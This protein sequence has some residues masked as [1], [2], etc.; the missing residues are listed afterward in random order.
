MINKMHMYCAKSSIKMRLTL[1]ITNYQN[2]SDRNR[3]YYRIYLTY[4]YEHQYTS[5]STLMIPSFIFL[6]IWPW[7]AVLIFI[8]MYTKFKKGEILSSIKYNNTCNKWPP[9]TTR[10]IGK[11]HCEKCKI[12]LL[13]PCTRVIYIITSQIQ[14]GQISGK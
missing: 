11:T 8:Y 1:F 3:C 14:Q 12:L 13:C 2:K 5:R 9:K 10:I 7:G 4:S 6:C